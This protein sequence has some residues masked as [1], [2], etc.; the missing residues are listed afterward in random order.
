LY[1]LRRYTLW[2][3][4]EVLQCIQRYS[5]EPAI[6]GFMNN[7]IHECL[8]KKV[9]RVP[10]TWHLNWTRERSIQTVPQ[11]TKTQYYVKNVWNLSSKKFTFLGLTDRSLTCKEKLS[12]SSVSRRPFGGNI[13]SFERNVLLEPCNKKH[14]MH[15]NIYSKNAA[16]KL[17]LHY[18][19]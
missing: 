1:D 13:N 11:L 14:T 7:F 12:C 15:S 6:N 18:V 8:R 4:L 5:W 3:G 10:S 17:L 19:Q 16:R 2:Q 9:I